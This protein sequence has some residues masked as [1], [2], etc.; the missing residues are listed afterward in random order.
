M[1]YTIV[2]LMVKIETLGNEID[3]LKKV[4]QERKAKKESDRVLE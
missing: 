1:R 3:K 2:A 4:G